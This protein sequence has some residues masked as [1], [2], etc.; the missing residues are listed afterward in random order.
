[1][2][3]RSAIDRQSLSSMRRVTDFSSVTMPCH[4]MPFVSH[5][6]FFCSPQWHSI[7]LFQSLFSPRNLRGACECLNA[8]IKSCPN[9]HILIYSDGSGSVFFFY[10][11][12]FATESGAPSW[13]QRVLHTYTR[14][15]QKAPQ[16]PIYKIRMIVQF[17]RNGTIL[18]IWNRV[19]LV[20]C[21]SVDNAKMK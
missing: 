16:R 1:M 2:A 20:M 18:A 6:W 8:K 10:L 4:A 9:I 11:L 5:I 15:K 21:D 13:V 7:G 19:L 17:G 14:C 3:L 12:S